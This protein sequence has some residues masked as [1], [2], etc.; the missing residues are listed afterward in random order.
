ML[1]YLRGV[2]PEPASRHGGAPCTPD[3]GPRLCW[4]GF[5]TTSALS[6]S[7]QARRTG[8][9]VL[10]LGAGGLALLWAVVGSGEVKPSGGSRPR[11]TSSRT[12]CRRDTAARCCDLQGTFS[13]RDTWV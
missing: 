2:K 6:T 10:T 9:W 4:P 7:E 1:L 8:G 12:K 5:W 3:L 13:A 11:L